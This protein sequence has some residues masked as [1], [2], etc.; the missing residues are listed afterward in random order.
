[1]NST[2]KLFTALLLLFSA[3]LM[4]QA[5]ASSCAQL[6][7][8]YQQYQSCATNLPFSNSTGGNAETF[9]TS[10]IGEAF[11]GPTWF[12]IEIQNSGP[13]TLQIR[14]TD[15][16]GNG[17]DVDFVLWG[18]FANLN[19]ICSQLDITRE[20]DCSWLADSVEYANIPNA[21]SGQLYVLLID[22]YS[23]VPGNI[24][25]TQVAG[26]G[27]S[28][29]DFLSSVNIV[30]T[31]NQEITQFDYCK[32][33]T[34]DIVARVDT[35]DFPGLLSN[36]RFNYTWYKDG[37][38]IAAISN[39]TLS[40]N[41]IT[42]SDT[43]LYK[44]MITAY[45]ITVNPSGSTTGLRQSTDEIT[46]KFH[47]IP[48]V[49]ISNTNTQCLSTNPVLNSSITNSSQLNNSIDILTYQWYLN[50]LPIAGATSA[51]YTPTL[52]G[53]YFVK[54]YNNPCSEAISNTI[55]LIASPNVTI[56]SD[57][58]ICEGDSFTITSINANSALNSS[59]TYQWYKD[60]NP[61]TGATGSTYTVSA[62]NQ[63]INSAATYYVETTE[64]I[65]CTNR[66]NSVV[67]RINASPVVNSTPLLL[68]Q[69]DY[70]ASSTDGIT[71][72]NLMQAYNYLTNNTPGLT[73]Y[74]YQ[75]IGLTNLITDPVHY[76]NN[77]SPF[78]Q[79]IYVKIVN[80]SSTPNCTSSA[81]GIINLNVNPTSIAVYPDMAPVCPELN[82]T[83][84]YAD[85]NAQRLL[86]KNTYFPSANVDIAFYLTPSD[87]STELNPVSNTY[88]L[89]VG[90]TT[91][92]TRIETNNN[93][94]GI[95]T[96]TVTITTPPTQNVISNANL[97]ASDTFLLNSKNP[98]ALLGQNTTVQASYFTT[99]DNAKNNI[100]PINPNTAL[101]LTV[102]TK[103]IFVRLY[104]S[105][106]QCISVVN[107]DIQVYPNPQFSQPAPIKLCG[108]NSAT[109]DLTSR[110]S[111]I[112]QNNSIL[113]VT[114]YQTNADLIAGNAIPTPNAF[115]S[116][117]TTVFVKIADPSNNNCFSTTT[118]ALFVLD[119]PG[120]T[121]N[122]TP[123]EICNNS[124]TT[125]FE[126]FNLRAREIQMVGNTPPSDI[127]FKYYIDEDD[128]I[129]NNI[130]YITN[131]TLF[132]NTI[133]N[134]QK[135]YVRL[136]SRVNTD[137]ETDLKC[138]RIL[139]LELFV[140]PYPESRLDVNP[141]I[142]CVDKDNY[143]TSPAIVDTYLSET[144]YS[145]IWYSGFNAQPGNEIAGQNSSQCTISNE[146][147]YS[148]KV[149]NISNA[150]NCA[151]V[152]NFTT[153]NSFVPFSITANPSE[154]IAFGIDNTVTAM[155]FPP[156]EDYLYSVNDMGWQTSNVFTNLYE[157]E[158]IL[159]V[160]NKY[161]CGET[162]TTFS[163]V[164]FP[165]YFTPNGDGFHDTWNIKG[166]KVLDAITIRIFDR[167]GKLLKELSPS[168]PGWDGTY[169]GN[170]LPSDDY[171]FKLI[172][173]K[174]NVTKEFRG[175]F[176]MKR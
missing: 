152:F 81:V 128:A 164:D 112:T 111:Q 122:P 156:S 146:G 60:G 131:P 82:M 115:T 10:C 1:M 23:N 46:L 45:D 173:T 136:N 171:W 161:G 155:V 117:T 170:T 90:T 157:A 17:S 49:S 109:F 100:S 62:S 21:I 169:N 113:Q 139:E 141:Y 96:F 149:T 7:A 35:S 127:D 158:Y 70:I 24:Q 69:C 118:L 114:F 77:S 27:S 135:I 159:K 132:T 99:F 94:D 79:T 68:E 120:A 14:Q 119:L 64:Q 20:T 76:T 108:T 25:I 22:N 106:T 85:F 72:T 73:L 97:C 168:G 74:F 38:Q 61:I 31:S 18:P 54:G 140:R 78:S 32:P 133:A 92:Y 150:A 57:T 59:L 37:V 11:H 28:N 176:A 147:S 95:G 2:V 75:D 47:I 123:I 148:V 144:D 40:T 71:E 56:A 42:V 151:S 134:Y 145:F 53:D 65:L 4:A 130:N 41:T 15:L 51:S 12:F 8:N 121:N 13:I 137:S 154:L 163:V 103:T 9:N 160:K 30:D 33:Q 88:Q 89:S 84:G 124:G 162:S 87:A 67:I 34:K 63:T 166:S 98:E 172:Y 83:Y 48:V 105:L 80:E 39:S 125:G 107:F 66:S 126:S 175:H 167:Y 174:D 43:G 129:A 29:C 110:I 101:P 6:Q 16:S 86:I 102:N 55:H 104:D 36:L 91:I 5:G 93:C 26:T 165:N 58:T 50:N 142:I 52:P 143:V 44:V 19:N 138:F 153:K 116:G 3:N